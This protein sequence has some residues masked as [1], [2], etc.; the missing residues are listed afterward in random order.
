MIKGDWP[1][2]RQLWIGKWKIIKEY[3]CLIYPN[4]KYY[5]VEPSKYNLT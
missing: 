3:K 1:N 4:I 5:L 2:S